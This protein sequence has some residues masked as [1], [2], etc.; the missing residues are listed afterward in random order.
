MGILEATAGESLPANDLDLLIGRVA[1]KDRQAF[2]VLY[3]RTS[4]KLFGIC[5]RILNDRSEA[6]DVLQEIYIKVWNKADKYATGRASVI[7]WLSTIARNQAIDRYRARGKPTDDLDDHHEI[8]DLAPTPEQAAL[9]SDQK[10]QID[11]CLDQLNPDHAQAVRKT[12]LA[13]WSYQ[14]SADTLKIPLNT[15]K[16]WIRR[17]LMQLKECL[18]K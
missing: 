8:S 3:Q 18:D 4:S 15:V 16:T 11:A 17:S 2:S 13:G 1:L 14:E 10:S 6:E 12:Y 9:H 7:A 5:L